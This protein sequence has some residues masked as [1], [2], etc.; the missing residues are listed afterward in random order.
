M[1]HPA[2]T[3]TFSAMFADYRPKPGAFDEAISSDGLR[4]HYQSLVKHLDALG[5]AT[6]QK[7]WERAQRQINNDGV[8]FSAR[9]STWVGHQAVAPGCDACA[10][11]SKPMERY[12]R[13]PGAARQ[14]V[15]VDSGGSL[16]RTH[17]ALGSLDPTRSPVRK[18]ELLSGL[19]KLEWQG[20]ALFAVVCIGPCPITGWQVVGH[21]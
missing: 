3:A 16:F 20:P 9:E 18:P 4:P 14:V 21:G 2:E 17:S 7:R 1:N 19:S 10:V 15:R 12:R 11:A 8:T 5:V 6:L 13:R